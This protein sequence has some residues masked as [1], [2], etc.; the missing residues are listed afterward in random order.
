M[1]QA[2]AV[3]DNA[4]MISVRSMTSHPPHLGA[5]ALAGVLFFVVAVT[6]AQFM[7]NDLDWLETPLSFYLLGPQGAWVQ[8]A[9]FVLALVLVLTGCGWNRTLQPAA[10][11]AA[12]LLLFVVAGAALATTAL[13]ESGR[14]GQD[15]TLESFVHGV[16]AQT[17]FLCASVAMLLQSWRLRLD[18]AWRDRF[19]TAFA[20]A[21]VAFIGLWVHALWREPPRGLSQK[22][23]IGVILSWLALSAEWLRRG[24]G[25]GRET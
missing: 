19:A 25:S 3:R 21:L 11:S 22:I 12:P 23:E 8:G 9:Y 2:I 20:L 5:A 10:R 15:P 1:E 16:A 14:A 13:A 4:A 18:P 6:A 17:A 24:A 7:R